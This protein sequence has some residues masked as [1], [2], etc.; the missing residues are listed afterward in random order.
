MAWCKN[1][2]MIVAGLALFALGA[3]TGQEVRSSMGLKRNNPDAFQV[4]T[5]PP[6]S[7]PPVYHLRPPAERMEDNLTPAGERAD[8]LLRKGEELPVYR[9]P[10]NSFYQ[11][12]TS[13]TKVESNSLGTTGD[14]VLLQHMGVAKA[15]PEIRKMLNDDYLPVLEKKEVEPGVWET[16]TTK[17]RGEGGDPVVDA[18]KE[19]ERIR[20]NEKDGKPL[21]EGEVPV[22]DP[23]KE[24][25]LDRLL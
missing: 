20:Q 3:C 19:Q 7:V 21:N 11:V 9:E 18:A 13:V 24:S 8:S 17:L 4:V 6:L 15:N 10:D 23:K 14:S 22:V 5:R 25:V 2:R 16:I 1:K 12:E